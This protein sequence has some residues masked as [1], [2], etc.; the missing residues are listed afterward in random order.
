MLRPELMQKQRILITGSE[1]TIGRIITPF[2]RDRGYYFSTTLDRNSKENP[3]DIL[4]ED[5]T[6]FLQ[7]VDTLIHLAGNA[8]PLIR[9]RE[10]DRNVEITRRIVSA[11]EN[12]DSIERII[13]ASSINVYPYLD[14]FKR[15]ERITKKTRL[16]PNI[17]F[18]TREYGRA[19]IESEK[20]FERYC[21]KSGV[22]LINLRFGCVTKD[23]L[24]PRQEDGYVEPTDFEIHLKHEDLK[25]IILDALKRTGI[26]SYVCVSKRNGLI[27]D[28]ILY[29]V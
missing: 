26:L 28:D 4:N 22:S 27:G 20:M 11:C 14:M 12:S 29:P 15:G 3:V 8:N 19:K 18:G 2:L 10:A 6:P 21:K 13:N 5:I 23:D 7:N 25:K 24:P 1:G 9:K 17:M 16:C